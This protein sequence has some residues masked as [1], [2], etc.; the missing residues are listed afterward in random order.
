HGKRVMVANFR[1]SPTCIQPVFS[2]GGMSWA[3]RLVKD[4]VEGACYGIGE[5]DAAADC[6]GLECRWNEIASPHGETVA[7][8]VQATGADP[9][10]DSAIYHAAIAAIDD[11]YG[12][13]HR[14]HPVTA[15]RL[16]LARGPTAAREEIAVRTHRS[17]SWRGAL[18]GMQVRAEQVLGR[19]LMKTGLTFAGV[20]WGHYKDEVVN[21]TDRRKFD[22]TLRIIL[23]GTAAE[24][25]LLDSWLTGRHEAGQLSYGL[26]VAQSALMTC[27]IGDRAAGDHIHFVDGA[28]G[29][30]ALAAVALKRQLG[31]STHRGN[32]AGNRA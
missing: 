30:Y 9:Q 29:G 18:Y 13:A 22:D 12:G 21:N 28:N 20:D 17:G 5:S 11:A 16:D 1:S 7:L 25:H 8:L 32:R 2:G 24:R 27:L 6:S 31:S 26:H 10:A 14:S 4:P 19:F 3:E 23:S 15:T